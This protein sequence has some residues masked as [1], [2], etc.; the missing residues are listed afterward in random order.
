MQIIDVNRDNAH[1]E[2]Y[3]TDQYSV[4][5]AGDAYTRGIPAWRVKSHETSLLYLGR[6]TAF[7]IFE[8]SLLA[9]IPCT[10]IHY[11]IIP[12]LW[13]FSRKRTELKQRYFNPL[14]QDVKSDMR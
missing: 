6:A 12:Y 11:A 1:R 3:R 2:H 9:R 14:P 13:K 4:Q 8:K 10:P 7:M 5:S